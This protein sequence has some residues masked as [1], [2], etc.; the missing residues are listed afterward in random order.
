MSKELGLDKIA[1]VLRDKH[2]KEA[3]LYVNIPY[4]WSIYAGDHLDHI[5]MTY[6]I[7]TGDG[8][9]V[10]SLPVNNRTRSYL[11]LVVGVH[12]VVLAERNLPITGGFNFRD[13]GG[14]ELKGDRR[15]KWGKLFR[16]DELTHLTEEDLEYL[17]GIP[18]TSV[19]DFRAESEIKRSP[20]RLPPSAQFTYPIAITPGAMRTEG[21]QNGRGKNSFSDQMKQMNRLYVSDPACVRA[22]RV[23]FAVIQNNLSAPLIFHCTAGK[24]RTG[25]AAALILFAL[26]ASEETVIEEYM[27]SKERI[28]DKYKHFVE[29][30]PRAQPIFTVKRSYIKAGISQIKKEYGSIND[31]LTKTLKADIPRLRKLYL[32]ER[33]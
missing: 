27:I 20:D 32:E 21:L 30:Y 19:I 17:G 3:T 12:D 2:T 23:M 8:A 22:Y 4:A 10:F 13:L 25:M 31:F 33:R 1:Y 28:A 15:I 9:G 24:D 29:R 18:I 16:A 26:G 7:L 11:R 6:P 5:D 14:I